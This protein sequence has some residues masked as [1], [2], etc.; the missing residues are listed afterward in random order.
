[1]DPWIK[2]YRLRLRR[3]EAVRSLLEY[4]F[5]HGFTVL[6]LDRREDWAHGWIELESKRIGINLRDP[7]GRFRSFGDIVFTLAHEIRHLEHLVEG[8]FGAYYHWPQRAAFLCGVAAER[9]CDRAARKYVRKYKLQ[10]SPELANRIYPSWRIDPRCLG[11]GTLIRR[12]LVEIDHSLRMLRR[13]RR[14]ANG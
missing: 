8:R 14:A 9:D 5:E 3:S 1:M 13:A 11:G 7:H 12:T 6:L 10:C 2:R 4:A